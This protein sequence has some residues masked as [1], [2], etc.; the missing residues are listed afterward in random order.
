LIFLSVLC[1][2]P[3]LIILLQLFTIPLQIL[4]FIG[5]GIKS[6]FEGGNGPVVLFI[7][8]LVFLIV[9]KWIFSLLT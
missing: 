5:E 1:G 4:A 8:F 3:L 9:L 2:L 7:I 6:I